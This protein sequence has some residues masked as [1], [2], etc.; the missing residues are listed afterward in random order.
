MGFR[1]RKTVK[2]GL[3]RIN[4]SKSGIS[5]SIGVPGASVNLGKR[6]PTA[7]LGLPGTGISYQTRLDDLV[8]P[9]AAARPKNRPA[10]AS[11]P[12]AA[13]R[14]AAEAPSAPAAAAPSVRLIVDDTTGQVRWEN[15][16]GQ[17]LSDAQIQSVKKNSRAAIE[18]ALEASCTRFNQ[19]RAA[20]LHLHEA[21]PAPDAVSAEEP[22]AA[23]AVFDLPAPQPP[24]EGQYRLEKP[25]P[26]ALEAHNVL[27]R[28]IPALG[29]QVDR[30][31]AELQ[32]AYEQALADWQ[33]RQQEL[34]RQR[35]A[36]QDTF[37]QKTAEWQAQQA[38]FEQAQQRHR[39][40]V[41]TG[42]FS[43][44][45][46]MQVY[47]EE[48]LG[49][50]EWPLETNASFEVT[51]NGQQV[52]VDID[53]PE[54]EDLPAQT[55]RV[56]HTRL[57][58]TITPVSKT[59]QQLSYL[60]HIHSIGFRI[61]GEVFAALPTV[62]EVALSAYSQRLSRQTAQEQD[63]YLYSVRVPRDLWQEINFARLADLD[64]V[65]S[66]ERFDLRRK[67]T[68]QGILT[69]VIPFLP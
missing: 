6:G 30:K 48:R 13:D 66:F 15:S 56:N 50:L 20:L 2:V 32:Q 3:L 9:K 61:L 67:M 14:R 36:D 60:T 43:D 33:A 10:A 46:A 4:F 26:P 11:K 64:V 35:S 34:E 12:T 68:Q 1:F 39:W 23:A 69:P 19:R 42:R 40:V 31:N 18:A 28:A 47:L 41:E 8:E 57:D 45:D 17:P 7:T 54:I 59:Q 55:A 29:Q 62:Q 63:E 53:L 38:A 52:F 51:E 27:T 21:T 5:T 44:P 24:D 58:L 16:A 25:A 65:A 49:A 22:S 37:A